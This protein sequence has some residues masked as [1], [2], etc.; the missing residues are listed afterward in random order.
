M[1]GDVLSHHQYPG[2]C[3]MS[4]PFG[5]TPDQG[6]M[7]ELPGDPRHSLFSSSIIADLRAGHENIVHDQLVFDPGNEASGVTSEMPA[8]GG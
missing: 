6:G 1:N 2:V 3:R 4:P 7:Q 8:D 5:S